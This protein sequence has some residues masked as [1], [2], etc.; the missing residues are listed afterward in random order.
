MCRNKAYIPSEEVHI[1]RWELEDSKE[2]GFDNYYATSYMQQAQK[3]GVP[4]IVRDKEGRNVSVNAHW[5][6]LPVWK[7][8]FKEAQIAGTN[9]V[10]IRSETVYEGKLY[11]PLL[12]NKQRC[13]IP[14]S[15]Y[16]EHHHFDKFDKR[17][18]KPLK[19]KDK[20]PFAL[21]VYRQPTYAVPALYSKWKDEVN[22]KTIVCYSMFTVVANDLLTE[23]HNGGDNPFRMPLVVQRDMEEDWLNPDSSKKIIDEILNYQ[24]T[25][26]HLRAHAVA[27][28]TGELAKEGDDVLKDYDWGIYNAE[29]E[30]I[31]SIGKQPEWKESKETV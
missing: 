28:L 30:R 25:S 15:F 13:L 10:N 9:F 21:S 19:S 16:F 31:K 22:N 12:E 23:I 14:L 2:G 5:G 11:K 20:V 7:K 27:P 29:I 4:L 26:Q 17:N 6:I 18:G 1:N 8:D 24:I 3:M